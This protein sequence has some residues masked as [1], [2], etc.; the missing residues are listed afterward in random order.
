MINEDIDFAE[1]LFGVEKIWYV[2]FPKAAADFEKIEGPYDL[3]EAEQRK[4]SVFD[5]VESIENLSE[6][7]IL[8]DWTELKR[9]SEDMFGK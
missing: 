1:Q 4:T 6:I 9:L 8:T 2:R 7:K 5:C 3:F